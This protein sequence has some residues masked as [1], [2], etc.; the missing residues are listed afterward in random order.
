[1]DNLNSLIGKYLK[2]EF[3]VEVFKVR[4]KGNGKDIM[5]IGVK[6]NNLKDILVVI[7]L[8]KLIFVIGV[9]GS[10]K[11]ILVNEILLKGF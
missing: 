10:G 8:F 1:M 6:E 9:F 2:G 7:L 11:F 5:I 4:C 3:K